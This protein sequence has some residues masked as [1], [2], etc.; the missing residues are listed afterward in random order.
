MAIQ[1]GIDHSVITMPIN[2]S[3]A[4]KVVEFLMGSGSSSVVIY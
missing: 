4:Q 3:N 2:I 1:D